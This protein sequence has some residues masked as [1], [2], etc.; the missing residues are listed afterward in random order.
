MDRTVLPVD[1]DQIKAAIRM[2]MDELKQ[3]VEPAGGVALA[4]LL[5]PEFKA[6]KEQCAKE[7]KPLNNVGLVVCGGNVSVEA[8]LKLLAD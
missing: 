2:S 4:G 3:V 8:L 1:D 7:G 6:L 5:S